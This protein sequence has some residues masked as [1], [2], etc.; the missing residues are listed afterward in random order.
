MKTSF[1]NK[2]IFISLLCL[3]MLVGISNQVQAQRSQKFPITFGDGK[4]GEVE[5][6]FKYKTKKI[7]RAYFL[8]NSEIDFGGAEQGELEISF[9]E[10]DIS[11]RNRNTRDFNNNYKLIV[12]PKCIT[13][14]DNVQYDNFNE[15]NVPVKSINKSSEAASSSQRTIPFL[16]TKNGEVRISFDIGLV[17]LTADQ[18][19]W[20]CANGEIELK[21]DVKGIKPPVDPSI[22]NWDIRKKGGLDDWVA[23]LKEFPNSARKN[24]AL[25]FIKSEFKIRYDNALTNKTYQNFIDG[26]KPYPKY[27][28]MYS[29]MVAD[30]KSKLTPAP[31]TEPAPAPIQKVER[32]ACEKDW[33]KIRKSKEYDDFEEYYNKYSSESK[34]E[35]Y[36]NQAKNKMGELA[37]LELKSE[38]AKDGYTAIFIK[39]ALN[40]RF[41]DIST[42]GNLKINT[43]RFKDENILLVKTTRSGSFEVLIEDELG[44][45]ENY[46]FDDNL[47]ASLKEDSTYVRVTLNKGSQPYRVSFINGTKDVVLHSENSITTNKWKI[48]KAKLQELGVTGEIQVEATDDDSLEPKKLGSVFITPLEDNRK[49]K[50]LIYGISAL[51]ILLATLFFILFWRKRKKQQRQPVNI[52]EEMG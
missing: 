28:Y 42:D 27:A 1:P 33:R 22:V 8:N 48:T 41:K 19:E 23:H 36:L 37:P 40:P 7:S 5:V 51:A 47:I 17:E 31:K 14:S 15:I 21:C 32:L 16:I 38:P 43:S 29:D 52:Y 4:D 26:C 49:T 34:C 2:N 46:T 44:K 20:F 13:K 12:T 25:G 30:M 9:A 10:F 50:Y 24:L 3:F 39:N 6:Y 45:K 11:G 18:S 35:E